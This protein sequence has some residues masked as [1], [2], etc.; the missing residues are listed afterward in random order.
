[1]GS[2]QSFKIASGQ[3]NSKT[4][5]RVPQESTY[6]NELYRV[7]VNWLCKEGAKVTAQW[8]LKINSNDKY[9]DIVVR[10]DDQV[11]LLKLLATP[12]KG[13][14]DEHYDYTVKPLCTDLWC[15]D[16]FLY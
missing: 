9:C 13:Q 8:H 15:T 16:N 1:M 4:K 11:I 7:L 6:K 3:V 12:T 2:F 10:K 5:V 14:L